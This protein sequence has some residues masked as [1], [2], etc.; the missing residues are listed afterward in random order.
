MAIVAQTLVENRRYSGWTDPRYPIGYWQ[1]AL[2]LIGDASGGA[3]GIDLVFQG[4]LA[5]FLNSQMYSVERFSIGTSDSVDRAM[6]IHAVNMSGPS[7]EGFAHEYSVLV[8]NVPGAPGT[9]VEPDSQ[10][11]VPW[12]LG[13]QRTVGITSSLSLR[14]DNVDLVSFRLEAEGYRWSARSVLVDGGPQ[15]PPTGPYR[16]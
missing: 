1:A 13:S 7:N 4:A 14:S 16:R 3:L 2:V 9:A 12:F 8:E 6:I 11:I 10:I 15:R 5:P